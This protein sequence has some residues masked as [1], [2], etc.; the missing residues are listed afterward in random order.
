MTTIRETCSCG[1]TF[2]YSGGSDTYAKYRAQEFR[3]DHRHEFA[4]TLAPI[5]PAHASDPGHIEDH[6]G[7][8]QAAPDTDLHLG[9]TTPALT[10]ED[11]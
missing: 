7:Y 11:A 5:E 3:T 4:P 10:T 8:P 2:D 9:F 1:A 6:T